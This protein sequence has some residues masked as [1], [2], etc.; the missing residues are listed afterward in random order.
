MM[1]YCS[2]H[3]REYPCIY[4]PNVFSLLLVVW[5]YG[6]RAGGGGVGGQENGGAGF[7]GGHQDTRGRGHQHTG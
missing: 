3:F 1:Q 4:L 5:V 7:D 6:E 2:V